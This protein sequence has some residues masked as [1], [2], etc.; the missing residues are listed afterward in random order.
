[1][2]LILLICGVIGILSGSHAFWSFFDAGINIMF[3]IDA[4]YT[5]F[6]LGVLTTYFGVT[7]ENRLD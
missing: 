6:G 2:K 4:S 1:M 3:A 7:H 5:M